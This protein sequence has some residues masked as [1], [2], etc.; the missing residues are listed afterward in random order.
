M[1]T[2]LITRLAAA[3]ASAGTTFVL[4]WGL[5]SLAGP[6]AEG[7]AKGLVVASADR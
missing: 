7:P 4:L 1:K 2:P 5:V 3:V 6:S